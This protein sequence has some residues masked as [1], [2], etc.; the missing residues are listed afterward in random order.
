M[1]KTNILSIFVLVLSTITGCTSTNT[2]QEDQNAVVE[3]NDTLCAVFEDDT[4]ASENPYDGFEEF[5]TEVFNE[6]YYEADGFI[7][8]YCTDN[9]REKLKAAYEYEGEG[10]AS[11]CFRSDN[12]DGPSE[13]YGLTKIVPEGDGWFK[14]DFVD[15]GNS[16]SHRIKVIAHET[17]R[18]N[19]EFYIDEI[20]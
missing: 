2:K 20:E 12:Q 8:K 16:G 10:Y 3:T 19:V 4:S 13:E 15:M 6:R 9:L 17:P 1:K 14:Y 7:E 5:F 18:G 11:W